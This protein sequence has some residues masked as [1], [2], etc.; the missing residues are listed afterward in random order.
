MNQQ[1]ND[2]FLRYQGLNDSSN[3]SAFDELYA[4]PFMFGGQT[5]VQVVEREGF[6]RSLPKMKAHLKSMGLFESQVQT[7]ESHSLDSNY[8]IAKVGW[9]MGIRSL[10]GSTYVDVSATFVLMRGPADA[11][12]IVFQIDHQDLSTVI[13]NQQ[14]E[15]KA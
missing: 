10:L 15:S 4:D 2:F 1:V 14:K 13:R 8:L 3:F 9:R 6:L 5:G 7:V 11:L 12:S